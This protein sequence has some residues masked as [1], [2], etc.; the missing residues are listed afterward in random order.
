MKYTIKWLPFL[1][2]LCLALTNCSKYDDYKK[3]ILDGEKVYLQRADSLKTY[4]G[5][6]RIQLEWTL[7]DPKVTSCKIFYEQAGIQEEVVVEIPAYGNRESDT[8]RVMILDLD[9]ATYSFKI[10]SYDDYGNTSI[11]VEAEEQAYGE[12]YEQLLLSPPVIK[13][14]FDY[15]NNILTLKWGTV[16]PTVIGVELNYTDINNVPQTIFIDPSEGTTTIPDF[17]LGKPLLSRTKHKPVPHSIDVFST[18]WQRTY[19]ELINNVV[20]N[21]PVKSSGSATPAFSAKNAV[22]GDRTT[23]ASRWI[24]AGPFT[25]PNLSPPQWM[26]VD[27]QE[28]FDISGFGMWRDNSNIAGSQKFSLQAWIENDWVDVVNENN[29]VM[30]EYSSQFSPVTTDKVRL[31][32]HPTVFADYMIRLFEIEVYAVVRY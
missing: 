24:S 9:E 32:I 28:Y 27:L 6:N 18:D 3:F 21:K 26:E 11:P 16:E 7:I 2:F 13:T 12:E 5:K 22:D 1:L 10:I 17:K 25:S 8:I 29:N 31:Y 4:P 14:E 30:R 23:P 15:E 19:I 20:L